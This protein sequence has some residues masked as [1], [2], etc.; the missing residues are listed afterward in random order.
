MSGHT[1]CVHFGAGIDLEG[2]TRPD[3]DE[4]GRGIPDPDGVIDM[5]IEFT[6]G[7]DLRPLGERVAYDMKREPGQ[8]TKAEFCASLISFT[9]AVLIANEWPSSDLVMLA[10]HRVGN[11]W[12][13]EFAERAGFKAPPRWPRC[14]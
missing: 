8:I 13:V 5:P 4:V 3:A 10:A 7:L 12:R 9:L 11:D 1:G 6:V 14:R 2:V